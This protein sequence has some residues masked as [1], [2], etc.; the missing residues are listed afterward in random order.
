MIKAITNSQTGAIVKLVASPLTAILYK[1]AFG[2][3]IF[4]DYDKLEKAYEATRVKINTEDEALI[5]KFNSVIG[6]DEFDKMPDAEKQHLIERMK[7]IG[8][9]SEGIDVLSLAQLTCGLQMAGE[10][11]NARDKYAIMNEQDMSWFTGLVT[12]KG[13]DY[14]TLNT[15]REVLGTLRFNVKKK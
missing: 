6:T 2:S 13:M 12:D 14:S 11:P 7:S 8:D 9:E 3:D 1:S 4:T 10:Y 5:T 15:I